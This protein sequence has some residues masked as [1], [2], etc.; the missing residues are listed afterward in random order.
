MKKLLCLL[1]VLCF[2]VAAF[3]GCG[4][5]P[6]SPDAASQISQ[7][8]P[9]K[10]SSSKPASSAPSSSE[11]SSASSSSAPS[12]TPA[13]SKPAAS[14][15]A[16]SK[17]SGGTGGTPASSTP[18]PVSTT[19]IRS[20]NT[21]S[22]KTYGNL[23]IHSD[24]E[25]D[26]VTLENV[27][28]TG[29]LIIE[30][31]TQVELVDSTVNA[32]ELNRY[33][34]A[35]TITAEGKTTVNT[36]TAKSNVVLDESALSSGYRGFKKVVT[37]DNQYYYFI[38]VVLENTDLDSIVLNT[39]TQL[40]ENGS[41]D[42]GTV[43]NKNNLYTYEPSFGGGGGG[44]SSYD[45]ITIGTSRTINGGTYR[46]ITI[47]S[48][49]GNGDVT[50]NNVRILGTL[51]INGGGSNS[52]ILSG[53]TSAPY[54]VMSPPAGINTSLRAIDPTT[55]VGSITVAGQAGN[56]IL[57]GP[58]A[59]GITLSGSASLQGIF[60]GG[61]GS[62]SI[63][64]GAGSSIGSV[65]LGGSGSISGTGGVGSVVAPSG[66]ITISNTVRG[67]GG[68]GSP[69]VTT[70]VEMTV[71]ASEVTSQTTVKLTIPNS[72]N[73]I[74]GGL[75]K[76]NNSMLS[77]DKI[78]Y[79]NDVYTLTVPAMTGGNTNPLVISAPGYLA[80][81]LNLVW[82]APSQKANVTF[83]RNPAD[84]SLEVKKNGAV[85]TPES[86]NV[87]KLEPGDYTYTAKKNGYVDKTESFTVTTAH[88]TSG[89]EFNVALN[90]VPTKA[91][92]SF[93]PTDATIVVKKGTT[94]IPQES[95]NVYKLEP[96][97]YTYTARKSGYADKADVPFTV[98][99][100]EITSG[101]MIDVALII[102]DHRFV[103]TEAELRAA[104]AESSIN[105]ISINANISGITTPILVN[106]EVTIDGGGNSLSFSGLEGITS[107]EDDGLI[108][109]A[110]ATVKNL[111]INAGLINPAAWSGSYG[112][113]VY[114]TTASFNNVTATGGNGGIL[115]NG[116][117]VTLSGT[118]NVSGNGFG[119]IEVAK[120]DLLSTNGT[121]A[122]IGTLINTTEAYGKPTVWAIEDQSSVT[123]TGVPA[124]SST[125]VKPGQ[126]HYYLLVKNS[127]VTPPMVSALIASNTD[128]Y[129]TFTVSD[130]VAVTKIEIDS[131]IYGTNN[132]VLMQD[133]D[134]NLNLPPEQNDMNLAEVYGMKVEYIMSGDPYIKISII[135]YDK[136]KSKLFPDANS[137]SPLELEKIHFWV[138]AHDAAGNRSG[139]MGL[140][141]VP[142][143]ANEVDLT[144]TTQ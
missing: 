107:T 55:S 88:I 36:L 28:I 136:F 64:L 45:S 94:E 101:K 73:K 63:S 65:A 46:N 16:S 50:L 57:S 20:G 12:S 89:L 31:S 92:V 6:S 141:G 2:A 54:V 86:G 139:H 71:S 108:L 27:K 30:G 19:T 77:S 67:S 121:L 118:T 9:P 83:N 140:P 69:T 59:T 60:G 138:V 124:Y 76:W 8:P 10:P 62:V 72:N 41:S 93:N 51:Y 49:V 56:I 18:T 102:D 37:S 70:P 110:A 32:I 15:P 122:I 26:I 44:S 14:K 119:G 130:N 68:T 5:R 142:A 43:S 134:F 113:H 143:T 100:G 114:G 1:M 115:V 131:T 13:S 144:L 23:L 123:G 29:T 112:V 11:A 35:V 90:A 98:T 103:A 133:F 127:D 40:T 3:A 104:L 17:P 120:G 53:S 137:G 85:V 22:D 80:K 24:V 109:Y 47:S 129:I 33:G 61:L 126:K 82:Y 128:R 125:L 96:G 116:S 117:T 74:N 81:T 34:S 7:A 4:P 87:Y 38:D 111:T 78:S 91:T 39:K 105:I 52:I 48:A 58:G 21:Y 97:D 84:L 106:R 135:D 132:A 99:Q 42:A 95:V 79:A 66:G 25:D 75:F